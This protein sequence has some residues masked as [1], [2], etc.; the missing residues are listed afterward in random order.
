MRNEIPIAVII[1]AYNEAE[2]IGKVIDAIPEW[3]DRIIVCDNASTDDTPHIAEAHGAV[4]VHEPRRGYGGACLRAME[5]LQGEEI[6]VFLDGDYSDYPEEMERLVDPIIEG[7]ADMVI[8]SRRLGDSQPGALTPQQRWGNALACFLIRI[9]W[10]ERYTDLGPFR[11]IRYSSLMALEMRDRTWGWT[12]EMQVRAAKLRIRNREAPVGYRRRIGVSKI[13]GTVRGVIAAGWKILSTIAHEAFASELKSAYLPVVKLFTKFPAAGKSKTRLVPA[14]GAVAAADLHSAMAA[15]ATMAL[16]RFALNGSG[17]V[18]VRYTGADVEAM[19]HWLGP[20]LLYREQGDGDLGERM[21]RA[22][23]VGLEDHDAVLLM[24]TDCPELDEHLIAHAAALL[25]THEVVVGP[26]H[27]GGYYLIGMKSEHASLFEDMEWGT[28][29]VFNATKERIHEMGLRAAYMRPLHDIDRPE[30]L[31]RWTQFSNEEAPVLSIVIP[32]LNEGECIGDTIAAAR[33]AQR[34]EVL[35]SDGGSTD[36]TVQ[37]A[38]NY[39]ANVIEGRKGRG[40][41]LNDG[42][43]HATSDTLLFLHGDTI[44]P[45][46]FAHDI[47][48]T[49][50]ADDA[51]AGAF[52]LGIQGRGWVIRIAERLA[53]LRTR[54]VR[55][56]YGDQALFVRKETF[57]ASGGFPEI[58]VM[59]DF[60]W[61]RTI[62]A[63]GDIALV[64]ARVRTSGRRWQRFGALRLTLLHQLMIIGYYLGVSPDRLARW[65]RRS[66]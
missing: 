66:D 9:I 47:T 17:L 20:D 60:A 26:A 7:H 30:D 49:L 12:V 56:P 21:R 35:V 51:V 45:K 62:G 22:V 59:E 39:G 38:K 64:D 10:G 37:L 6:I 50:A 61:V 13:S 5:A 31:D 36:S 40:A 42:A 15:R 16:R 41:Q 24:G 57:T 4:V 44:L 63:R 14:V 8:G 43:G 55:L 65:R 29:T 25:R 34:V 23:A 27:D 28:E 1:P 46:G 19:K 3:V 18:E 33:G 11:A 53:D 32:T 58:P 54:I 48:S 2:A 52:R